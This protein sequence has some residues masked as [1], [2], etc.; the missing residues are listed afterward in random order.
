VDRLKD[1]NRKGLSGELNKYEEVII[2]YLWLIMLVLIISD[3]VTCYI[4]GRA[5][6][7]KGVF[8]VQAAIFVFMVASIVVRILVVGKKKIMPGL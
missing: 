5:A 4:L 7:N 2:N 3:A 8:I 6:F 1:E